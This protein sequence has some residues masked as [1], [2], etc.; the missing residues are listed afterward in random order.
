MKIL[1][2]RK[3][4]VLVA[5]AWLLQLSTLSHSAQN[6]GELGY[7]EIAGRTCADLLKSRQE[8]QRRAD[9]IR[10]GEVNSAAETTGNMLDDFLSERRRE[11]E[12]RNKLSLDEAERDAAEQMHQK[13]LRLEAHRQAVDSFESDLNKNNENV[14]AHLSNCIAMRNENGTGKIKLMNSCN[15]PVNVKYTFSKSK[16][17][18]GTYTTLQ[19]GST[20]LESANQ[21]EE[22]VFNVCRFPSTPISQH[23]G[24]TK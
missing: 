12:I 23:G 1:N 20:T 8:A 2:I 15:Y 22:I 13:T 19:P 24:C 3:A 7:Q 10:Q 17:M 4:L 18:S 11:R 16:P 14:S 5:A 6:C 9:A 21:P